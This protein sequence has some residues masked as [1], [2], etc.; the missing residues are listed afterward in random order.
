MKWI[1][2]SL[3]FI[4]RTYHWWIQALFYL[5]LS[6]DILQSCSSWGYLWK[7]MAQDRSKVNLKIRFFFCILYKTFWIFIVYNIN[8]ITSNYTILQCPLSV[9]Q[10]S[11]SW[12]KRPLYLLF[13]YILIQFDW[14][15]LNWRKCLLTMYDWCFCRGVRFAKKP[16]ETRRLILLS[17][18]HESSLS[19]ILT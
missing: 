5:Q 1:I 6:I 2:S 16:P 9:N 11:Y 18:L 12:Y 15:A 13:I 3:H 17:I 4:V 19:R 7:F 14:L 10:L 8:Y